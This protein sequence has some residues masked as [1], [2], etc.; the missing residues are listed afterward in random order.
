MRSA[1]SR[2]MRRA[3]L[4]IAEGGGAVDGL[5]EAPTRTPSA[6]LP[7][8]ASVVTVRQMPALAIE[9]P[10]GMESMG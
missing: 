3:G 2:L 5:D 7:R 4:P 1:R 9:A 8:A 6:V 10:I